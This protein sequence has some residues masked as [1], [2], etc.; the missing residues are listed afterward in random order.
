M[1]NIKLGDDNHFEVYGKVTLEPGEEFGI[2][3]DANSNF[4]KSYTAQ[5]LI[6]DKFTGGGDNNITCA[7]GGSFDFYYDYDDNNIWITNDTIVEAD[8]W[9]DYFLKNSG[10]DAQGVNAPSGW[11]ACSSK[12]ALLSP[13]AKDIVYAA[14][15]TGGDKIASA[16][17]RYDWA[18]AHN[19]THPTPFITNGAGNATRGVTAGANQITPLITNNSSYETVIIVVIS[20]ISLVG[21][22]AF[23]FIKRKKEN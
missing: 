1:T 18:V 2:K 16:V 15:S 14:S 10:C 6:A 11:S 23:F 7:E 20:T 13:D 22:G 17:A 3:C 19:P 4:A 12:Y 8:G 21:L 5:E 9:A